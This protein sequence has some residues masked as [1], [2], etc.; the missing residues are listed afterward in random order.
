MPF[1]DFHLHPSLKPQ[2]SLPPDFPSPWEII[3]IQFANPDLFTTLLKCGG[4]NHV[5]DSQAS[6]SQLQ[7][8]N[9]NLVAIALHP[10]ES[11]MMK[12]AL[13]KKVA[14]EEQT[15]YIHIDRV[16]EISEGNIYFTMLQEE[17][18]NLKTHVSAHG[19]K[20]KLLANINEYNADDSD[21]VF[22]LLTVEG[23]HA[24]YGD[25]KNKSLP[26]ILTDF[27]NNFDSFT[28]T[29]RVFAMNIAHLQDNDFCN[30]AFGIQIFKPQPFY[31]SGN[32]ISIH[33]IKLLQKM[34]EKNIL[35]DIKHTS[36]A[37]RQDLYNHR[38][39][40]MG[41]PIVC[42][43]AGLTGIKKVDRNKYFFS[44]ST[45]TDG[46]LKVKHYKPVGH[47]RRTS[48]NPSSINLYDEDVQQIVFSGGLIGLSLD[49]RILGIPDE[50]L[51][52]PDYT[53]ELFEIEI[54][55][56]GEKD[57]FRGEH[58]AGPDEK[59][60]LM[61][62]DILIE[63]LQEYYVFHARHF[64]N[65]VFHLFKICDNEPLFN[66]AVMAQRICIGSDFDGLINSI[67]CC[68]NVTELQAFKDLLLEN[69][70]NW[71]K[72]FTGKTGI[73]VSSFITPQQLLDNIFYQNG[74]DFL[75]EWYI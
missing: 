75:R 62:D 13:I 55:S 25:R 59:E 61:S 27:W 48:F 46:F 74:L 30:H 29:N 2:M 15:H 41:W 14:R 21:T 36:L 31:P 18:T 10:P 28:A 72:E 69:F 44:T 68:S 73:K 4:I 70:E 9:V 47:L 38:I 63:D 12:D 1:F 49:Q 6:L 20:L 45:L 24:F 37:A 51:L 64:L 8:G 71:E 54:I 16:N 3:K 32:G 40:E 56:P 53:E 35:V 19:K 11:N 7:E 67:D 26:E 33:G 43:H 65:Q 5:V 34:K 42:T 23:P 58:Q 57:F 60:V 66:K 17:L 39:G 50:A 22:A 52:S